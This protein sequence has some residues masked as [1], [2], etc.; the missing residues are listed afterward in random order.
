MTKNL[1]ISYPV[2]ILL[3]EDNDDHAEL[4]MRSFRNHPA[5]QI[6]HIS[7]GEAAL[8]YLFGRGAY[9]DTE[10]FPR[11]QMVLLDLRL[12]K[13]DGLDVLNQVRTSGQFDEMPIVILTTSRADTDVGRAY[14]HRANSYLVKPIDFAEFAQLMNDIGGYW[15]DWNH[16]PWKASRTVGVPQIS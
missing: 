14:N 13:V 16:Y 4:V 1:E 15:L 7:D 2:H 5:A 3:V 9:A 11:P 8:D 10:Q 12:P 6:T